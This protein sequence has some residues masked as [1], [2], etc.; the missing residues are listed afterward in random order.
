[1]SVLQCNLILKVSANLF[2][3]STNISEHLLCAKCK[4]HP[5]EAHFAPQKPMVQW[6]CNGYY[7]P[8]PG[9]QH[10]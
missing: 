9:R 8:G 5:A 6:S 1:M 3:H 4:A 2:T 10:E 7:L